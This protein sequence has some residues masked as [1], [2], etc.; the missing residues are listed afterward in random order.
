MDSMAYAASVGV[1]RE[2]LVLADVN[3]RTLPETLG[4]VA[5]LANALSSEVRCES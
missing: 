4:M 1:D 5:C 3:Q 2:I